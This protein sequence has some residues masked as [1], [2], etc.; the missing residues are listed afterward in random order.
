MNHPV[1]TMGFKNLEYR[2]SVFKI[3][4]MEFEIR[5]LLQNSQPAFLELDIVVIVHIVDANNAMAQTQTTLGKM[6]TDESRSA[7]DKK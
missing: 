7:R 6:E 4:R 2:R 1:E 5:I 3:H